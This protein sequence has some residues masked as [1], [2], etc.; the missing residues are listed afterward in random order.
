MIIYLILI[1]AIILIFAIFYYLDYLK[2]RVFDDNVNLSLSFDFQESSTSKASKNLLLF[3]IKSVNENFRALY[4][5]DVKIKN[6]K[7][8]LRHYRNI[9][10]KLPI[11][12]D[13]VLLSMEVRKSGKLKPQEIKNCQIVISGF[14]MED[15]N[16]K[17]FFKRNMQVTP[18]PRYA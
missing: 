9:S 4:I 18:L 1:G 3:H 14:L 15:K 5:N 10:T 7:V 2:K 8:R 11:P 13:G 16:K 6:S 17:V 12:Q